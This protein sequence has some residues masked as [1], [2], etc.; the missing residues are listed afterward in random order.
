MGKADKESAHRHNRTI[1][2][3]F[4]QEDYNANAT[5]PDNQQF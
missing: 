2:L 4:S 3:P 5:D 1:C